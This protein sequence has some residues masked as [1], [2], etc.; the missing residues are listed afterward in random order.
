M[1]RV[2]RDFVRN[3]DSRVG[4]LRRGDIEPDAA[5]ATADSAGRVRPGGERVHKSA[6]HPAGRRWL[7]A[8]V[9]GGAGR[10]DPD[11]SEWEPR[12]YAVSGYFELDRFRRGNGP[13]GAGVSSE[14]QHEWLLLRELHDHT[15]NG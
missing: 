4:G 2:Y 1:A 7:G 10:P 11:H 8:I 13:T 12:G 6:G 5:A 14:L 15:A 3:G 9:C